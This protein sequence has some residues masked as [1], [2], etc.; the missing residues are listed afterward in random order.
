MHMLLIIDFSYSFKVNNFLG[1]Q[2][3]LALK[4]DTDPLSPKC[5]S[6]L[7]LDSNRRLTEQN[8]NLPFTLGVKFGPGTFPNQVSQ[9]LVKEEEIKETQ[10][11]MMAKEEEILIDVDRIRERANEMYN[12]QQVMMGTL[13]D[14][15]KKLN[16][17]HKDSKS[18]KSKK[19]KGEKAQ[20]AQDDESDT[21]F[22]RRL[23]GVE[24]MVTKIEEI[25]TGVNEVKTSVHIADDKIA[26]MEDKVKKIE[27]KVSNMEKSIEDIKEMLSQLIMKG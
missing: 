21:L 1:L 4:A 11:A 7:G 6:L 5:S 14:I 17:D 16:I 20:E 22:D 27:G 2:I 15:Q 18:K 10:Q 24:E 13:S 26:R 8:E 12:N 3:F 25:V 19:A 9:V 23:S